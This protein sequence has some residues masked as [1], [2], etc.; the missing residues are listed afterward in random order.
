V[1]RKKDRLFD[2]LRHEVANAPVVLEFSRH[3]P[4]FCHWYSTKMRGWSNPTVQ[5]S[6]DNV[7]VRHEVA[8]ITVELALAGLHPLF[9]QRFPTD[10]CWIGNDLVRSCRN[11]VTPPN[12]GH[13][14][15]RRDGDCQPQ[16]GR[17]LGMDRMVKT[18]ESPYTRRHC[19][20]SARG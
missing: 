8:P 15:A 3:N 16:G 2:R 7:A 6:W 9:H 4:M 13:Q 19:P 1:K 10:T 12:G 11:N 18:S 17:G 14:P 20:N 5:S